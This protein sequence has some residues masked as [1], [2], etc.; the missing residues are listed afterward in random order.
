MDTS[1]SS[2]GFLVIVETY[3]CPLSVCAPSPAA[4]VVA[5]IEAQG[6]ELLD[7]RPLSG[8]GRPNRLICGAEVLSGDTV[9]RADVWSEGPPGGARFEVDA[10]ARPMAQEVAA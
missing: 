1:K 8:P 9:Y 4:A 7:A 3:P 2:A 10:I 5:A 6:L